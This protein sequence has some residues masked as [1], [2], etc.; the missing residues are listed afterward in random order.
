[1]SK[2]GGRAIIDEN[3]DAHGTQIHRRRCTR[4]AFRQG[5]RG[6]LR[7]AADL[8]CRDQETR[9]RTRGQ[10]LRTQCRRSDGHAAGRADRA[11][12]AKRAGPGREHQGNRQA[13]ER[14]VVRAAQ[15][16]RDLHH[17]AV[18]AARPGAPEHR[19]D[20]ADAAGAAGKLHRQ[21]ARDAARRRD[22]LRDHGRAISRHGT[23]RG[24][25]LRRAL[26]GGPCRPITRWPSASP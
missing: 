6:L 21:A 24:S 1:V 19:T 16:G 22:R 2:P 3:Y 11:A 4:A 10:A 5:C 25:A 7:L 17:R 20:A 26:R 23:G 12:G 13:R 9:G 18:L 8:V 15:P 14:P